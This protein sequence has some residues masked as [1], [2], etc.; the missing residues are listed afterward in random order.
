MLQ[1][2]F[3][4]VFGIVPL[5]I[6]VEGLATGDVGILTRSVFAFGIT[7]ILLTLLGAIKEKKSYQ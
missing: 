6:G 7:Y 5:C 2:A 4:I 1:Q 3:L